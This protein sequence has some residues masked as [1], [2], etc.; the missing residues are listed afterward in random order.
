MVVG[1]GDNSLLPAM[2]L[3]DGVLNWVREIKYLCV[4]LHSQKEL[5]SE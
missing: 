3:G 4:G 5:K 2:M 1:K